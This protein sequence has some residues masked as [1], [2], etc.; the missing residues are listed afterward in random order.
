LPVTICNALLLSRAGRAIVAGMN[1]HQRPAGIPLRPDPDALERSERRSIL[2]AIT[3]LALNTGHDQHAIADDFVQ[4]EWPL[5]GTA[6]RIIKGAVSPTT[7]GG[8][9]VI[10]TPSVL[11]SLAPASASAQLFAK[12]LRLDLSG[13]AKVRMPYIAGAPVPIFITEGGAA[14]VAQFTVAGVDVGPVRKILIQTV[15]TAELDSTTPG[16]ASAVIGVALADAVAKS[17]DA[18]VFSTAGP[19]D[20]TTPAGLLYNVTPITAAATGTVAEKAAADVTALATAISAAKVDPAGMVLVA[21]WAQAIKLAVISGTDFN[22][23][24]VGTNALPAGT[25]AAFA[26]AGV[27]VGYA[28]TPE[29]EVSKNPAIHLE[30]TTPLGISTPGSPPVVSAPVRSA[31][32]TDCLV[33][34]VRAKCAWAALPGA[35]QV[36]NSVGW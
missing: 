21:N 5:D 36:M 2:H 4:R 28:G 15:V 1:A 34:K 20:G 9:P 12:C 3:A 19:D 35:V 11:Q 6:A 17:V 27:G 23:T 7:T 25:V 13:I 14:P 32:Q 18:H 33:I 31:W 8:Y 30:D 16:T 10:T 26:P 24:I 29:I 22:N